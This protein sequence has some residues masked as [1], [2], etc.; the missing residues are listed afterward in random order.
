MKRASHTVWRDC[1][2]SDFEILN[3]A[4]KY[5]DYRVLIFKNALIKVHFV[6]KNALH[7]VQC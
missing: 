3:E 4:K 1:G 5:C 6:F 2:L 7:I